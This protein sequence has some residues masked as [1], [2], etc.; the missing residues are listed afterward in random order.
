MQITCRCGHRPSSQHHN[1]S[2]ERNLTLMGLPFAQA[3][4]KTATSKIADQF[5]SLFIRGGACELGDRVRIGSGLLR[6]AYLKRQEYVFSFFSSVVTA[7]RRRG[8]PVELVIGVAALSR[9]TERWQ[10]DG[11]QPNRRTKPAALFSG[12]SLPSQQQHT[13][14][15]IGKPSRAHCTHRSITITITST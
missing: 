10:D 8:R 13:L 11:H 5:I 6:R 9:E 1:E 2:K 14:L 12:L 7:V 15:S 3:L 4:S